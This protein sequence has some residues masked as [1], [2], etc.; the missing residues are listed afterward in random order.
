MGSVVHA[1]TERIV[2]IVAIRTG[3]LEIPLIKPFKTAVRA[4]DALRGV[5]VAVETDGGAVGFGEAPPTGAI[6]GDTEGALRGA[7]DDYLRPALLGRDAEDLDG[8]LRTVSRALVGN[9]SAKAALDIALH[10]L[11]G[12]LLHAPLFRLFGGHRGTIQTDVTVSVNPPEEMAE[13]ARRAV[14]QGYRILKIKVGKDGALDLARLTAVRRAVGA[15]IALR[16]DANQGWTPREAVRTLER[17]EEAGLGIELVE[18]PVPAHDRE[19][20]RFVTA[21]TAIPVAADESVWSARDAREILQDRGADVINIK[22]MKCGGLAEARRIIAV[23]ESFGAEVMLGCMLE[24]KIS[25]TAAAHLAV[26]SA[27]V[28]R[29]DLDG[30]LLCREDPVSGGGDFRGP[31]ISLGEG[32]GLDIRE[33]R[34]VAWH[35]TPSSH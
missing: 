23:A 33:I 31:E 16:I 29:I 25:T 7:I 20:L 5:I 10:D 13:D 6:T 18:Q 34:H 32:P 12:H 15:E 2:K 4:T 17:M 24:G 21:H 8:N 26:S 9:T 22:L 14:A 1:V 30:P 28:T 35:Q 19:G 27:A 11:W 3:S